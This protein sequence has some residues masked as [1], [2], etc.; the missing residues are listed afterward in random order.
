MDKVVKCFPE[1]EATVHGFSMKSCSDEL[2]TIYRKTPIRGLFFNKILRLQPKEKILHRCFPVSFAKHFRTFFLQNTN[3]SEWLPLPNTF[4]CSLRRPQPQK[5][6][7]S[8]YFWSKHC[9]SLASSSSWK[10]L[11]VSCDYVDLLPIE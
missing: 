2:D 1:S 7:P 6:F 5:M 4:F 10:S 8:N 3:T 9:E 11:T